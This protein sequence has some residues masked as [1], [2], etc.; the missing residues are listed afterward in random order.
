[1]SSSP[2]ALV[3]N[4]GLAATLRAAMLSIPKRTWIGGA[5]A[6]GLWWVFMHQTRWPSVQNKSDILTVLASGAPNTFSE[7]VSRQGW[8]YWLSWIPTGINMNDNNAIGMAFAFLI[9]GAV[10]SLVLPQRVVDRVL[11]SRGAAGSALGGLLG[12]P[13]MMCSACSVPVAVG[14]RRRGANL[15]TTLGVVMGAALLNIV[16]L[17]TIFLL[18]PA[19]LAWGRIAASVLMV[20]AVAPLMAKLAEAIESRR[21]VVPLYRVPTE[22]N[23]CAVENTLDDAALYRDESLGQA[24]RGALR[25]WWQASVELAYRLWLPMTGAIFLAAIFR[26]FVPPQVV[27]SYLGG[28][29]A[30]IVVVALFGTLI[31]IPTMFEIPLAL[32]F[33]FLGMGAGPAAALLVTA[34]SVSIVSFFMLRKDVGT[35]PPVLLMA[36]TFLMGTAIGLIVGSL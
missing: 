11:Y 17:V 12:A 8:P 36:A 22:S 20:V 9:G 13:L 18:F 10:S 14:W 2:A 16:G 29:L 33:M 30:A 28:G 35:L 23:A 31:A 1:M 32:G 21:D 5:I 26:L 7:L 19:P 27:E 15:E 24:V 34:P 3:P 4:G 6:L 25:S